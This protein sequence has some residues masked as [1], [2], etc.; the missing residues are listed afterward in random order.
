MNSK[1]FVYVRVREGEDVRIKLGSI[2]FPN[3]VGETEVYALM[4]LREVRK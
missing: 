4:D 3:T 1:S 2:I